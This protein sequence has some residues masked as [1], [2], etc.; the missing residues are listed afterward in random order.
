VVVVTVTFFQML[1][2]PAVVPAVVETQE[3][4]RLVAEEE[5]VLKV[6]PAVDQEALEVQI[7]V[8]VVLVELRAVQIVLAVL[9]VEPAVVRAVLEASEVLKVVLKATHN[10]QLGFFHLHSSLDEPRLNIVFKNR[11][12]IYY[13]FVKILCLP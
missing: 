1:D 7:V 11:V 3:V 13:K 12:L 2:L 8:R 5:R 10:T 4:A 6:A 9:K